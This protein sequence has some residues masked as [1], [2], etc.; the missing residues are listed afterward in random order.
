MKA[1]LEAGKFV[2]THGVTGELKLY[3]WCDGPEFIAAL[4]R[5]FFT[6]DGRGETKLESVRSHKGMCLVK[7]AGVLHILRAQTRRCPKAAISCRT[8][9]AAKCATPT[10][11]ASTAR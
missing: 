10:R 2:T 4:P 8:S 7:L 6:A 11:A 1:Y 3:P 5:L 9:S